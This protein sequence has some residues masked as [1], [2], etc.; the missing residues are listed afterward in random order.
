MLF[1]KNK[2]KKMLI[3]ISFSSLIISFPIMVVSCSIPSE[4]KFASNINYLEKKYINIQSKNDP[5]YRFL[6]PVIKKNI[7][8]MK[9]TINEDVK[10][11]DINTN[12]W[13]HYIPNQEAK[14]KLIEDVILEIEKIPNESIESEIRSE[15]MTLLYALID[16]FGGIDSYYFDESNRELY[17]LKLDYY[18]QKLYFLEKM[19]Y[20]I[21]SE[22]GKI[23]NLSWSIKTLVDKIN[24]NKR[25][26]FEDL[27]QINKIQNDFKNLYYD[28]LKFSLSFDFMEQFDKLF[29]LYYKRS[30]SIFVKVLNNYYNAL[31]FKLIIPSGDYQKL[32]NNWNYMSQIVDDYFTNLYAFDFSDNKF[33]AL[34]M[35]YKKIISYDAIK[36]DKIEEIEEKFNV[37]KND[38]SSEKLDDFR[39]YLISYLNNI[40]D[41]ELIDKYLDKINKNI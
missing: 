18:E 28:D 1:I 35:I 12:G 20:S 13:N 41:L 4:A 30:E 21:V 10:G 36:N 3:K 37:L 39:S 38:K 23:K 32:R 34:E 33:D 19:T 22:E 5:K 2:L 26:E 7:D 16:G 8:L 31:E 6:L 40:F 14:I 29:D 25:F 11:Y 17:Q 15:K 27:E 9:K 24:T